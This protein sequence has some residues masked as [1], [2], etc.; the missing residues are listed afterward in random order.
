MGETIAEVYRALRD[1][2]EGGY[3]CI[4]V[5]FTA[6]LVGCPWG[7]PCLHSLK[8]YSRFYSCSGLVRAYY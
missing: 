4:S 6:K 5:C 3:G 8:I 1:T 7:I 2:Q